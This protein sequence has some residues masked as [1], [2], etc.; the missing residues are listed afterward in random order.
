MIPK[1]EY[2]IRDNILKELKSLFSKYTESQVSNV[3]TLQLLEIYNNK[4]KNFKEYERY[5][6]QNLKIIQGKDSGIYRLITPDIKFSIARSFSLLKTIHDD[7]IK[8][9]QK[10]KDYYTLQICIGKECEDV[11]KYKDFSLSFKRLS[12]IVLDVL[13]VFG[14]YKDTKINLDS[15]TIF[16]P[17][18]SNDINPFQ[19]VFIASYC[20]SENGNMCAGSI[21]TKKETAIKSCKEKIKNLVIT[22]MNINKE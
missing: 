18:S 22:K 4:V 12:V 9:Y 20:D 21:S 2:E 11:L 10:Y 5:I 19:K 8:K 14:K 15:A 3:T 17:T 16:V 6:C 7:Y 13:K 1:I